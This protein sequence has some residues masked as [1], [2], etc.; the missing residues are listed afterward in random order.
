MSFF[1]YIEY[2]LIIVFTLN[3]FFYFGRI[4]RLYFTSTSKEMIPVT[5]EQKKLLGV[6]D[7]GT[8]SLKS[9]YTVF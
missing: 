9:E 1:H 4:V 7:S 2:S 5:A 3:V 6:K 8:N